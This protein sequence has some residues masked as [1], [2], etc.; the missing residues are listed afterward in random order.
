M[1]GPSSAVE[2]AWRW[3]RLW[4]RAADS[5][6][7]RLEKWRSVNLALLIVGAVLGAVATQADWPREVTRTAAGAAAFALTVSGIVQQRGLN[8]GEVARWTG[9]RAASEALKA[10]VF[11]HLA[12]VAPYAGDD[13][14]ER[15]DSQVEA[16]QNKAKGLLRDLQR[17]PSDAEPLPAVHDLDSYLANRAREQAT[18]HRAKIHEHEQAAARIRSAEL[19]ATLIAALLAAV[20]SAVDAGGLP[21]WI[22]VATTLSAA[23]AAHANATQ[24][25]RI[26]AMFAATA[27]Q[28]DLLV[29]RFARTNDPA[30]GAQ[31]VI[32][33]EHRLATQ[34][35]SWFG[36]FPTRL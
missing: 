8:A 29:E 32:D 6:R 23:L 17:T 33:V 21:V 13:R 36:V 16:I 4:S 1:D 2:A 3:H 20:G 22:G 28:L 12:G 9:A 34:N 19:A 27:M 30:L 10:E 15:L 31:F 18:W 5:G 14:D 24:H 35:E 26:A 7:A 11:R 25:D